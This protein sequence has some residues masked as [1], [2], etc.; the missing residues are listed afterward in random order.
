M[1]TLTRIPR[2]GLPDHAGRPPGRFPCRLRRM[3]RAMRG[4]RRKGLRPL[5]R[6]PL[7]KPGQNKF[8]PSLAGSTGKI[9]SFAQCVYT[10]KDASRARSADSHNAPCAAE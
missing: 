8:G 7:N 10:R 5:R 3:R 6:L 1:H 9:G 2:C 4:G